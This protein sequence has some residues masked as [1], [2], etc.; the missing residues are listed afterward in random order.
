MNRK[1]SRGITFDKFTREIDADKDIELL[2]KLKV[3]KFF[4]THDLG[5][6]AWSPDDTLILKFSYSIRELMMP[7]GT[8]VDDL[9]QKLKAKGLPIGEAAAIAQKQTKQVLATGKPIK[10]KK[11]K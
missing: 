2:I 10:K 8:K 4:E 5:E 6:I 1:D 7:T 3:Q 9:F 11:K